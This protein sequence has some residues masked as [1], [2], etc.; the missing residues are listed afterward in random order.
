[1]STIVT[2]DTT[3]LSVSLKKNN[4]AFIVAS[5]AEVKVTLVDQANQLIVSGDPLVQ[6]PDTAG[7]NWDESLVSV[8]IPGSFTAGI[9]S[10][11][12]AMLEIQVSDGGLQDTWFASVLIVKG[13]IA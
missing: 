8:L 2:G 9:T 10:F 6:Q 4:E 7:A 11:G 12:R 5:D 1:M 13:N 3:I